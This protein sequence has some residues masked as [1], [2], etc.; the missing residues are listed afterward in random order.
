MTVHSI[1]GFAD[2]FSSII[3]LLGAVVFFVLTFFLVARGRGSAGRMISL[4]I[5]A[6][7]A[8]FL[9]SM[10]GVYHLLTVG[11]AGRSVLQRLDHAG[12]F[13]L[14]AGSFTPVH[15]ILF[16]GWLRWGFLSLIWTLAIS[17]ITLK[18]IFF[19]SIPEWLGLSFYLG[20]GWFGLLSGILLSRR[21]G[22]SFIKPLLY[23]GLSYSLGGIGEF[24]RF[25]V[26]IPGVI[27]PHELFHIAVIAGIGFHWYFVYRCLDM[28]SKPQG[29]ASLKN[30]SKRPIPLIK[31]CK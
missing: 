4:A 27:G 12:I 19:D 29:L 17:G 13:F 26:P 8:V 5:F 30:Q 9:L 18:V 1:P 7:S 23:S 24:L 28:A 21:F 3:H 22:F 15:A 6:F 16:T 20:L 11:G 10:S 2:P 14:I 25:P 31:R